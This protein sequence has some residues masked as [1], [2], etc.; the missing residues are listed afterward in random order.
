MFVTLPRGS[1]NDSKPDKLRT[2]SAAILLDCFDH[3][4]D[5]AYTA[6]VVRPN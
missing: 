2:I 6:R 1:N 5:R 4:S 3:Q